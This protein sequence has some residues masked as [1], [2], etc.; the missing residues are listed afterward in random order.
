MDFKEMPRNKDNSYCCGA[1]AGVKSGFKDWAVEIAADRVTEAIDISNDGK[2]TIEYL[3]TTCPFCE[4]NL[5]DGLKLL[6]EK[7]VGNS[8]DLEVIDLF[9]LVKKF[10]KSKKA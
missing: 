5:E 1:G 3:V 7:Q 9:Q 8:A 10:L 4:R 2:G 6:I